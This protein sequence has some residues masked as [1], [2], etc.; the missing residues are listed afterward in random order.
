MLECTILHDGGS[1]LECMHAYACKMII[2]LPNIFLGRNL[3]PTLPH[4]LT[5]LISWVLNVVAVIL[6]SI[7]WGVQWLFCSF[8][9]V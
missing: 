5:M 2:I 9:Y 4:I 8:N 3:N 1:M 6:L 7:K